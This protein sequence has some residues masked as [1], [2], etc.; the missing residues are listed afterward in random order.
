MDLGVIYFTQILKSQ[1]GNQ[2]ESGYKIQLASILLFLFHQ[3]FVYKNL[4]FIFSITLVFP[5]LRGV[6]RALVDYGGN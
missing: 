5:V 4:N 6:Y 2:V 1:L 3:T